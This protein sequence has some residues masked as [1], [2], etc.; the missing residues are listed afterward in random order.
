MTPSQSGSYH[1]P[2]RCLSCTSPERAWEWVEVMAE[3]ALEG[4]DD[5]LRCLA[6]AIQHALEVTP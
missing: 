5:A 2:C 1:L 4:D 6:A 3:L